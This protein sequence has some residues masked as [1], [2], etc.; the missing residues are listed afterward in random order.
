MVIFLI[1]K[2]NLINNIIFLKLNIIISNFLI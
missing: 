1:F 2:D